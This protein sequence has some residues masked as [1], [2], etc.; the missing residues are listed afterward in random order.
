MDYIKSN[1]KVKSFK[2]SNSILL[3]KELREF[4][5]KERVSEITNFNVVNHTQDNS[6]IGILIYK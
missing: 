4:I 5:K 2:S 6:L 3:E 1:Y